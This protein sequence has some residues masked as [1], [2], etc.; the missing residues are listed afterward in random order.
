M[1]KYGS[2]QFQEKPSSHKLNDILDEIEK[3]VASFEPK[4]GLRNLGATKTV[5]NI[6]TIL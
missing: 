2:F 4:I 1:S 3:D 6:L 5:T